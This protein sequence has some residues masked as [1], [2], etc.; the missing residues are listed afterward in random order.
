MALI[1]QFFSWAASH[2][3]TRR[4]LLGVVQN[5]RFLQE[6]GW[7]KGA[8][9]ERKERV[10]WGPGH[11]FFV[12]KENWGEFLCRLTLLCRG[13][14][15]RTHWQVTIVV[16]DQNSSNP[17]DQDYGPQGV[18]SCIGSGIKSRFGELLAQV[19]LGL[20]C[21]FV[22]FHKMINW[23]VWNIDKTP[24]NEIFMHHFILK[25]SGFNN[26]LRLWLIPE[27]LNKAL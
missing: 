12:G 22:F 15:E 9:G 27:S 2:L 3:A 19:T 24:I 7:G 11:I 1:K 16:L 4:M 10:I 26:Q 21:F 5:G 25:N 14:D 6:A 23:L 18:W 13:G 17:I 20:W 8:L